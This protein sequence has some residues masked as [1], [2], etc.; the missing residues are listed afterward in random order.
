[1][2]LSLNARGVGDVTIVH[3]SGRIVA[4]G[5]TESLRKQVSELLPDRSNVILH[6][7]EIVFIDSSGL[8]MLVRLLTSTRHARGDLKLCNLPES[9]HKILQM[10]SL[11]TLFDTHESEE[12]A[13]LA[14]Y[15]RQTAPARAQLAGLTILCIDQSVDVLAYL[16]ELLHRAGYNVLT[17]N[18]LRDS[19]ILLRAT[20]PALTILGPN[21][22]A[23]PATEQAFR[24]ACAASPLLKL[25][26]EFSTLDAGRA[27]TDLLDQIRALHPRPYAS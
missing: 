15:R 5:E 11:I 22:K 25:G 7:G 20:R 16:R 26:D 24:T 14:F 6:L 13:V 9:I 10:T 8:G 17:N 12:N 27:A 2:P 23:S 1:M 3:C 4:G 19:L 18:N 21:L